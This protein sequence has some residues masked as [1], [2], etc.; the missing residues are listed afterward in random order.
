MQ[1]SYDVD[2]GLMPKELAFLI[3]ILNTNNTEDNNWFS[4]KETYKSINWDHF[5]QLAI[6]HRVYPIIYLR[7]KKIRNNW[8]PQ[9]VIKTL[10]QEY[11]K[12]TYQ[13]LKLSAEMERINELFNGSNIRLLFLKGPVIAKDLYGDISL[14]TSR[15]LD[16]LISIKDLEKAESILRDYG[17]KRKEVPTPFWKLRNHHVTYFHPYKGLILEIHWRLHPQSINEP[18]F[19][20]LWERRRVSSVSSYSLHYL[21]NEDLFF[22]LVAHGARHGWFRL[23]WLL[24]INQILSKKSYIKSDDRTINEFVDRHLGGEI[25]YLGQALILVSVLFQTS[26]NPKMKLVTEIMGARKLT[27]K[28]ITYISKR[29]EFNSILSEEDFAKNQKRY[30]FTMK[31]SHQKLL[32]ILNLFYP[33]PKDAEALLLPRH[34]RFLYLPLRPFLWAVRKKKSL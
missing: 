16:I 5:L 7:F 4:Y 6:Y 25:N 18:S 21:G 17:Y 2:L 28:T 23:R 26:V 1:N 24:D 31:S 9:Y 32:F 11:I 14:R 20:D 13:M 34:L 10:H 12:N 8:I 15:D 3:E 19:D 33:N 22:Y 27:K 29:A 30:L